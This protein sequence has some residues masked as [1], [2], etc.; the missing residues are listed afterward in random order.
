MTDRELLGADVDVAAAFEVFYRRHVHAVLRFVAAR[1]MSAADAA[2]ITAET[3]AAVYLARRSFRRGDDARNWVLTVA[4]NQVENLRRRNRVAEEARRKLQM[5]RV[6]I[7]TSDEDEYRSLFAT[8]EQ[9]AGT[10]S[11]LTELERLPPDQRSAVDAR[12]LGGHD[13]PEIS[14]RLGITEPAARQRVS[15]GL[16]AIRTRL[17]GQG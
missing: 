17:R 1:G 2:D 6:P 9:E 7:S 15:R 11:V 13:Y 12:I 14:E 8:S 3:F 5:E 10:G 16:S 4:R